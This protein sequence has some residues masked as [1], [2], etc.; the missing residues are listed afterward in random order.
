MHPKD[1]TN[2]I[3]VPKRDNELSY[4]C[5][6]SGAEATAGDD[7][8]AHALGIETDEPVRASAVV[9]E[10]RRGGGGGR[11]IKDYLAED[12]VGGGEV[13]GRV[14]VVVFGFVDGVWDAWEI[15]N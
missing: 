13:E 7:G 10:E 5:I 15:G 11:D 6:E 9:G 1:L 4:N 8:G 2:A 14:R 12:D 3:E